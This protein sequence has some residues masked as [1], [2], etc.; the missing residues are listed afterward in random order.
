[1]VLYYTVLYYTVLTVLYC[2]ILYLLYCTVLHVYC[3]ILYC[4]DS[5]LHYT[6]LYC[7]I[8]YCIILYYTILYCTMLYCTFYVSTTAHTSNITPRYNTD[9]IPFE[10]SFDIKS[11]TCMYPVF[12]YKSI[13][14]SMIDD[15]LKITIYIIIICTLVDII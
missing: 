6:A 5:V 9:S 14:K 1:M 15:K 8:L 11:S 10:S 7:I 12:A 3:I 13:S 2:T 4:A